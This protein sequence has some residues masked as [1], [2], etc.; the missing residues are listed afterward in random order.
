[1]RKTDKDNYG[2]PKQEYLDRLSALSDDLL[3]SET[4]DKIWLSA[5]ASN[6]PR[7]DFHWQ[8]DACYNEWK[9]RNNLNRYDEAH[10]AVM[11]S[12]GY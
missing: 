3:F 8:C 4:K 5:Y 2:M 7:S 9:K 1:M 10:K 11:A 12:C 6:N